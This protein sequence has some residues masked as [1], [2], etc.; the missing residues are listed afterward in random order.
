MGCA[1]SPAWPPRPVPPVG[2]CCCR[3]GPS[4]SCLSSAAWR[5]V[6]R[7]KQAVS[8]H[9]QSKWSQPCHSELSNDWRL[10]PCVQ[11]S[12]LLCA[13]SALSRP[14]PW[15]PFQ[16][17]VYASFIVSRGGQAQRSGRSC[18][19]RGSSRAGGGSGRWHGQRRWQQRSD[20]SGAWRA[21]PSPGGRAV[22]ACCATA[23]IRYQSRH[24]LMRQW[25][26]VTCGAS[27]TRTCVPG[28]G[29][30]LAGSCQGR[31]S[32]LLLVRSLC[33]I[34]MHAVHSLIYKE[35]DGCFSPCTIVIDA[36]SCIRAVSHICSVNVNTNSKKKVNVNTN[37]ESICR[38]AIATY[39]PCRPR[40]PSRT[41]PH[42]RR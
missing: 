41:P 25:A 27:A 24:V 8:C 36:V 26:S 2:E 16:L 5:V 14:L 29:R 28:R 20:S 33:I 32:I 3:S 7:S 39:T 15:G 22:C 13:V 9:V 37:S 23:N 35:S 4:S 18:S 12:T 10:P 6:A 11:C 31:R 17:L 30:Q 34:G 19:Q 38:I 40:R 21:H 42:P 1:P